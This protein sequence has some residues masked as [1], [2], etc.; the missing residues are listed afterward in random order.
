MKLFKIIKAFYIRYKEVLLYLIFGSFT[1]VISVCSYALFNVCFGI[2]E[3]IA[4]IFS[5]ILAVLFAYFTNRTWV[6]QSSVK[7]LH[8]YLKEIISFFSGRILT[9]FVEEVILFIF[10]TTLKLNSMVVKVVAQMI[11]I[12]L[13][14]VVSKFFVFKK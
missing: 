8:A 1:F 10:I 13:N 5:W 7:T 3:L 9:L 11:V 14:Y 2:N 12:I 6:F 4:N